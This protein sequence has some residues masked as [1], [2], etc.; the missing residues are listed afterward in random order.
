MTARGLSAGGHLVVV[1]T[2]VAGTDDVAVSTADAVVALLAV[3]ARSYSGV[4]SRRLRFWR[5]R[6]RSRLQ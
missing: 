6:S 4:L 3:V 5:Q 1:D 2:D